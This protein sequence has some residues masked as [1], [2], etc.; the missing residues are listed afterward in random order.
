MNNADKRG[1]VR[2]PVAVAAEIELDGEV[3]EG[4][5]RDI[6]LGGVS[7][8]VDEVLDEGTHLELTL[9]LIEDGIQSAVEEAITTRAEVMWTAPTD[10]GACMAGLRFGTLDPTL[11]QRLQRFLTA[12]VEHSA[13]A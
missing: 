2:Y 13:M 4:E 5:T 11:G 1:H 12:V 8:L 7:V 3:F 6:S 9:M 10:G